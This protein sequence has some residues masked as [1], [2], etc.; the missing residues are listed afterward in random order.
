[1]HYVIQSKQT[2]DN[3]LSAI[4]SLP[5]GK[6]RVEVK[7]WKKD[8]SKAQNRLYWMWMTI[9]SDHTGYI[10]EEL[11]TTFRDKYLGY[12]I[13]KTVRNKEIKYLRSTTDLDTKEFTDY[14]NVIELF[15]NTEIEINLP[16]PEDIYWEAMGK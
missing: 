3:C 5:D 7:K 13:K 12:E 6:Y 11:H 10:K 4:Q 14:L 9:I 2:K 16:H 8:R 15:T 1:M